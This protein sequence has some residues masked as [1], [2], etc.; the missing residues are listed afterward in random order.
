MSILWEKRHSAF[1]VTVMFAERSEQNLLK[2][3]MLKIYDEGT[4]I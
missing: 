1:S 3:G 4:P 2:G